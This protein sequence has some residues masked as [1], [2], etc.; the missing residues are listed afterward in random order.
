MNENQDA[1]GAVLAVEGLDWR[2]QAL[3]PWFTFRT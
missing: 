2:S 3:R 1:Q